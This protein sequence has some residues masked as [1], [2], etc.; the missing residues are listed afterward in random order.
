M[1]SAKLSYRF[2]ALI[3]RDSVIC[4]RSRTVELS[5]GPSMR[6]RARVTSRIIRD[7][8]EG[9]QGLIKLNRYE[10]CRSIVTDEDVTRND[11]LVFDNTSVLSSVSVITQVRRGCMTYNGE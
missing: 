6:A 10:P 5:L 9:V 2:I 3:Y 11:R 4:K 1:G 7:T 8:L